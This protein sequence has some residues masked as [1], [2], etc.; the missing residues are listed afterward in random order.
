MAKQVSRTWSIAY[1]IAVAGLA[2]G[3]TTA[4][5]H[6]TSIE[7]DRAHRRLRFQ[8]AGL[9]LSDGAPPLAQR[10]LSARSNRQALCCRRFRDTLGRKR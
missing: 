7:T 10:G 2:F 6:E 1:A 9:L 4:N 3:V 5:A 8:R